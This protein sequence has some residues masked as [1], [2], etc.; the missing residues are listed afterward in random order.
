MY[1]T[2]AVLLECELLVAHDFGEGSRYYEHAFGHAHHDHLFCVNCKHIVEFRDDRIETLQERVAR[3]AGFK[4]LSHSLKL[5][6]LCRA[7]AAR[8]EILARF[9]HPLALA[10]GV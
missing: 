1:R 5:F 2:L 9:S 10:A 4:I 8:P 7:C 3:E 6:G